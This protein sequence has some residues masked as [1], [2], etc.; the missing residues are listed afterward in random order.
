M[1]VDCWARKSELMCL[2]LVSPP[3]VPAGRY[4]RSLRLILR[5]ARKQKVMPPPTAPSSPNH[6]L[7]VS[8]PT[9]GRNPSVSSTSTS[10]Q[11]QRDQQQQQLDQQVAFLLNPSSSSGGG[12]N[13]SL[14][15][16]SPAVSTSSPGTL[17]AQLTGKQDSPQSNPEAFQY[18]FDFAQELWSRAGV[19][20]QGGDEGLPL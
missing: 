12:P 5:R 3:A 16:M 19:Q 20:T 9:P 18:D 1:I 2:R 11:Q 14:P 4:S 8:L 7:S 13:T 17:F 10:Q 15:Q 6:R